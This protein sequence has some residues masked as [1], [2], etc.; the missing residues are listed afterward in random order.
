MLGII[1]KFK[2]IVILIEIVIIAM[3]VL[4]LFQ[5][6]RNS[7]NIP[8]DMSTMSTGY[9][10]VKYDGTSWV[11]KSENAN[12]L[13]GDGYVIYGPSIS[14]EKGSYTLVIN[15]Q[16]T[17][18]QKG[19]IECTTGIIDTSDYFLLSNN[20]NEIRYNFNAKT[21][22]DGFQFRLKEYTGGDFTLLGM[23]VIENTRE[24]RCSIFLWVV[25]FII[26]NVIVFTDFFKRYKRESL[27]VL[28]IAFLASI[29]FLSEGIMTGDD[30]RY[31]LIRIEGIANGLKNGVFPVKMYSVFNDDYGYPAGVLYGDVLLYIPAILRILG[32]N[33]LQSYKIYIFI[34][35]LMTAF[36]SY[37]CGKK[38]FDKFECAAL[39]SLVFSL[40]T[41][42]LVCLYARAAVGEY[43]ATCFYPI[44][45]LAVW[46]IYTKDVRNR[47]Y[48]WNAPLLAIGMAGVIYSH[49]LSTEMF[50]ITLTFFALVLCKKTFRKETMMVYI[51]AVVICVL[52]CMAF[53]VPFFEYYT[54]VDMN[55]KH[56][57]EKAY[58]QEYGAYISDYFTFFKSITG[59]SYINR[60]ILLTPGIALVSALLLG[61]FLLA[62]NKANKLVKFLVGIAMIYLFVASNIFPWNELNEIPII[63]NILV[64]V[65]FPYR[66][67]GIAV[68][69]LS[70]LLIVCVE[71]LTDIYL[72]EKKLYLFI[73]ATTVIMT[74]FFISE[75]RDES[76]TTSIMRVYDK[77]DLFTYTRESDFGIYLGAEYLMVGT[78]LS[79]EKLDYS[80]L[81]EKVQ[82]RIL[83]EEDLNMI[84]EVKADENATL[85]IPR[86]SYPHYVAKD[87][88][89]NILPITTGNN[90]KIVVHF[91][92]TYEGNIS[93]SFVEPFFWRVAEG[94]SFVTIIVIMFTY[95]NK[96]GKKE[97]GWRV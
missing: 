19:V 58:I 80:V 93:I 73:T 85:E 63:G 48:K 60:R 2:H 6:S 87:L 45:I 24:I 84:I 74:L 72:F 62:I 5:K 91:P 17:R 9:E 83:G 20:K 12:E 90:N 55:I 23:T 36:I 70:V 88:L 8:V 32:F 15:Y 64:T 94:I 75:Y 35:N 3:L 68:C 82:A 86:F 13:V 61:V 96:H 31:H 29:P 69:V 67:I 81:G 50:V 49:I 40:S 79:L 57:F 33:I 53:V 27:F 95:I 39:F 56:N 76:Y 89:G 97:K 30:I 47:E 44:I 51:G 22:I 42:R 28:G 65:Q 43:T 26:I 59:G 78:D 4:G 21:D 46:N 25:L 37:V 11:L 66:Y 34:V 41:Y 10:N 14:L 77:A 52:I 16:T 38:M 92:Y 71:Q 7:F 18:I 1:R 54:S